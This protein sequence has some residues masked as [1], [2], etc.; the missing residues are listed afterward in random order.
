[1]METCPNPTLRADLRKHHDNAV[2]FIQQVNAARPIALAILGYGFEPADFD[3][4]IDTL[5]EEF[6]GTD[7]EALS[8]ATDWK[9]Q[10]E[11]VGALMEQR[12]A[13]LVVGVALGL[14]LRPE[15]FAQAGEQQR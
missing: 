14:L 5:I 7:W 12:A 13:G 3:S 11:I 9:E 10:G 1:M 15:T 6:S 4:T 8:R 2:T